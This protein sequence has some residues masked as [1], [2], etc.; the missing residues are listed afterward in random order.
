MHVYVDVYMCI[1]ILYI[2]VRWELKHKSEDDRVSC[3]TRILNF[4]KGYW[5]FALKWFRVPF[6]N[7]R[8][9]QLCS[10]GLLCYR[11]NI[12]IQY[13]QGW[14]SRVGPHVDVVSESWQSVAVSFTLLSWFWVASVNSQDSCW[15]LL[16]LL[17]FTLSCFV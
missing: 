14:D 11:H 9:H 4:S 10:F 13:S 2:C 6:M 17:T 3:Y 7:N 5:L 12:R 1:Y 16:R 8:V 15:V